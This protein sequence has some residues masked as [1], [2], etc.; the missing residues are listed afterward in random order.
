MDLKTAAELNGKA[1]ELHAQV[2]YKR[3]PEPEKGQAK[4]DVFERAIEKANGGKQ[5]KIENLF[6]VPV[7]VAK[8]EF[9]STTFWGTNLETDFPTEHL[10]APIEQGEAT[11]DLLAK[12]LPDD[13]QFW[14][15][16]RSKATVKLADA[17]VGNLKPNDP[18]SLSQ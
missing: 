4:Y 17:R 12:G 7:V 16:L 9:A 3:S 11:L 15:N 14:E 13:K 8:L 6:V 5:K 18:N 2:V 10:P 1:V